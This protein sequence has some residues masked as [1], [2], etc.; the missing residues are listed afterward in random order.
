M[1]YKP[2]NHYTERAVEPLKGMKRYEKVKKQEQKAKIKR[3]N[4][5]QCYKT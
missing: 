4:Q 3:K 2:A 5:E 1:I